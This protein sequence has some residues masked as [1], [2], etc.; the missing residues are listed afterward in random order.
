VLRSAFVRFGGTAKPVGLKRIK[1]RLFAFFPLS[2]LII[3]RFN[4]QS[5]AGSW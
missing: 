1:A 4:A 2:T 5:A 3:H